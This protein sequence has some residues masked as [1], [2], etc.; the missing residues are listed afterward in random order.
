MQPTRKL[1]SLQ[2]R[3][4]TLIALARLFERAD[5]AP[6]SVGADAYQALVAQL[7]QAVSNDV[8]GPALK[9]V[10]EAFPATAELYENLHYVESGLSRSPLDRSVATEMLAS[11]ALHRAAHAPLAR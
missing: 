8:P 3:L 2:T 10:L 4:E 5:N 7:K 9:A 1:E 6:V 11:Q